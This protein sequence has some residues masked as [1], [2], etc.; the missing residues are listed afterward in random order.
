MGMEKFLTSKD[1]RIFELTNELL[2]YKN[3]YGPALNLSMT[4][5]EMPSMNS[6]SKKK[7]DEY[8]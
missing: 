3:L 2:Y 8:V 5:M 6:I 4:S 7:I 1:D